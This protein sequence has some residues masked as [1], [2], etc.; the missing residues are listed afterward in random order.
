MFWSLVICQKN[1]MNCFRIHL[2]FGVVLNL[3]NILNYVLNIFFLWLHNKII[4]SF[5]S[6]THPS[7]CSNYI[8]FSYKLICISKKFYWRTLLPWMVVMETGV[9]PIY[10]GAWLGQI[11]QLMGF[12][13]LAKGD[14]LWYLNCHLKG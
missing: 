3:E 1:K 10:L 14:F 13:V 9:V 11:K 5:P 2:V 4:S 8:A 6:F 7:P 12:L